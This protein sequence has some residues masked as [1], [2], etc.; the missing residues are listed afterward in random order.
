MSETSI[1]VTYKFVDNWHVF[2]SDDVPGLYV[3]SRDAEKAYEDVARSIELMLKLNMGIECQARPE[4]PFDEFVESLQQSDV[5]ARP[6]HI[7]SSRRYLLAGVA[8]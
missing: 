2:R 7:M 6:P 1:C 4:Q 5:E 8:V 3:A